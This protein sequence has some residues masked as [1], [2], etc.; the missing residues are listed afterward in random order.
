MYFT[1]VTEP[2]PEPEPAPTD[3]QCTS[4]LSH[5][6][7][8]FKEIPIALEFLRNAGKQ[9]K[10]MSMEVNTEGARKYTSYPRLGD[11]WEHLRRITNRGT[12]MNV[13]HHHEVLIPN[14]IY[15]GVFYDVDY[16]VNKLDL[17]Q[18]VYE[19]L[20]SELLTKLNYFNEII[21]N[22]AFLYS[23][24]PINESPLG[25]PL[26]F[27]QESSRI[28]KKISFHVIIRHPQLVFKSLHVIQGIMLQ[29]TLKCISDYGTDFFLTH[30]KPWLDIKIYRNHGTFRCLYSSK[31]ADPTRILLPAMEII[32]TDTKIIDSLSAHRLSLEYFK[33]SIIVTPSLSWLYPDEAPG[34][35]EEIF[36]QT[37]RTNET[38]SEEFWIDYPDPNPNL[39]IDPEY[40]S[41]CTQIEDFVG[42]TVHAIRSVL[43][44]YASS[45]LDQHAL[46]SAG[47]LGAV[48]LNQPLDN[49]IFLE[50]LALFLFRQNVIK[51]VQLLTESAKKDKDPVFQFH[52]CYYNHINLNIEGHTVESFASLPKDQQMQV[53][54]ESIVFQNFYVVFKTRSSLCYIKGDYH[55]HNHVCFVVDVVSKQWW[56]NCLSP[57]CVHQQQALKSK[58]DI[59]SLCAQAKRKSH[60]VKVYDK[61]DSIQRRVDPGKVETAKGTKYKIM[62]D[63]PIVAKMDKRLAAVANML[64]IEDI[65]K[66]VAPQGVVNLS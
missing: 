3:P 34:E 28:G 53:S 27:I 8:T 42:G 5:Q 52:H 46:T 14:M 48:S 6:S 10:L 55:S 37:L 51:S 44:K 32:G 50:E 23:G 57:G 1:M 2:L 58:E 61:S 40:E 30:E 17:S 45:T 11:Y 43:D 36:V 59:S 9:Q 41:L 35:K 22:D 49:Q 16:N 19:K 65:G 25:P 64:F 47:L 12:N 33:K 7:R 62:L 15:C 21:I 60:N 24:S 63:D 18:E 38:A 29:S 39:D 20:R 54:S 66:Q 26:V 31:K 56:Q 13:I 4:L